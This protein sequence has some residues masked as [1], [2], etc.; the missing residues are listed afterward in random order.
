MNRVVKLSALVL[1]LGVGACAT[2]P[3]G[4]SV[5]VLPGSA[6][7]FDQFR[8]DEAVC[9]QYANEQ[10]AGLT[11]KEAATDS[12]VRSAAVGTVVGAAAGALI[13]GGR[14]AAVGAGT[15]LVVGSAVGA[16]A[17]HASGYTSQQRYD[18]AYQQCMYAKG[19]K[20]PVAGQV[21]TPRRQAYSY[22]PPPPSARPPYPY[23]P[24]AGGSYPP[25]PPR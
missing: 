3:T 19:N 22:Y 18:Y 4:P 15:G 7:S 23:P 9:R 14:G 13:G 16:N 6:K 1:L 2:A 10:V 20:I 24:S 25:P 17:A 11:P 5:F 21:A 12:A 8:I